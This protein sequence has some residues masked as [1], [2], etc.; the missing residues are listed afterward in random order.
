[1]MDGNKETEHNR[2]A[3]DN[4][5]ESEER[6]FH[7]ATLGEIQKAREGQLK[8][9]LTPTKS[10][11][12]EWLLNLKGKSVLCLAGGGGRQG[13]LLAAAGATV[14]VMDLSKSQLGLDRHVATREGLELNSVAGD[15]R[16]LSPFENDSFDLVINPTSICYSPEV[17]VVWD[18]CFRVL[19]PGGELIVGAMNPNNFVF[20]AM[21]R[22]EGELVVRHK[23]PYSDM[24]LD[25][26]EREQLK[27]TDWPI[28]FGHTLDDL[29]GGQTRA[30][31]QIVGFF[32]DRW[33]GE[34]CLSDMID[35]FFCTRAKK[36]ANP[37]I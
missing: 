15:M 29:I 19:K 21:K 30:G 3:W 13:P 26:A 10:V 4:V 2:L 18:E 37:R 32:E 7:V 11:P 17:Q 23:I 22:D 6:F 16:D 24:H 31:L 8:I 14:T 27:G 5:A 34:D 1:M 9:K 36:P 20:D 28:E 12:A 33:G 25:K 35:V